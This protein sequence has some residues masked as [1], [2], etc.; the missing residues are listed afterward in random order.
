VARYVL[1]GPAASAPLGVTVS[2]H[3]PVAGSAAPHIPLS[4]I[5][6]QGRGPG[7]WII[8]KG[9]QPRVHWTPV[10]LADLGDEEAGVT[11]GLRPGDRFVALGAHMLHDEET[12]RLEAA[13][14]EVQ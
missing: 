13:K 3:I 6:D 11:S 14:G 1:E 9:A 5:H 12:V 8:G 2:V 10:T 4:A 7:V